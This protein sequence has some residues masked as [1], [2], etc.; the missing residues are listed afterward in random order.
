MPLRLNRILS[1]VWLQNSCRIQESVSYMTTQ[2]KIEHVV[3]L[4]VP[5]MVSRSSG[6]KN[7]EIHF[8]H[9]QDFD[10]FIWKEGI[11]SFWPV[12]IT[13]SPAVESET[14]PTFPVYTI[15]GRSHWYCT[16]D[17]ISCLRLLLQFLTWI[18]LL[19]L[20]SVLQLP[21]LCLLLVCTWW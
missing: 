20:L 9:V 7:R 12:C 4:M 6:Y 18:S 8:T 10:D 15:R 21:L 11:E 17:Y 16:G 14:R 19:P 5:L 3:W 13:H 2:Q 1:V